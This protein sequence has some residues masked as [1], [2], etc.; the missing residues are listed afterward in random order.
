MPKHLVSIKD[1]D[2]SFI[3]EVLKLAEKMEDNPDEYSE[4]M[5]KKILATIFFEPSTRTR[6]S[7]ESAMLRLGGKV[8]GF[9]D[10]NTSSVKKGESI[11][12]TI[13]MAACYADVIVMRHNLEGSGRV[14][15]EFSSVPVISGG[16]GVQEHPTQALLDIYTIYK[17]FGRLDNLTIGLLGD[18]RYG[19][20]IP[21]LL[22]AFM[23]FNNIKVK[24][25]SPKQLRARMTVLSDVEGKLDFEILDNLEDTISELDVLYVTRIQKERFPDEGDYERLKGAF[26]ID[27]TLMSKTKMDMILMHPLPRVGEIA[28]EVDDLPQARYFQQAKNGVWTRMALLEILAGEES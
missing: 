25:Y 12:D 20:T 18:L 17:E 5:K 9:S 1:I 19:R 4:R 6:L 14:A 22:Y 28:Y 26:E 13:R 7:F 3:E 2:R 16:T 24:L 11:A 27:T 23:K 21:S 10:P 15:A 8:L